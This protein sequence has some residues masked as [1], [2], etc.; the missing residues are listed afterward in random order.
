ME[1][2]AKIALNSLSPEEA[3]NAEI[4][5]F[6]GSFTAIDRCYMTS[7]LEAASQ[8]IRKGLFGGIRI[9][10]RPDAIDREVLSLLGQYGVT[11]IELGAQSMCDEVLSANRRGHTSQDVI[12]ASG[13]ILENG[14]SLGLQMMTGLYMSND[15]RDRKTALSLAALKPDT[16]RI[17]PTLVLKGSELYERYIRGEYRPQ[18]LDEAVRLCT[19]LL[20]IFEGRGIRVIRL[21]LHD[22]ES[23]RESTAAGPYHPSLRELCLSEQLF[24]DTLRA[25]SEAGLSSGDVRITVNPRCVSRF[26]GQNRRNIK[27]LESMGLTVYLRQDEALCLTDVRCEKTDK[28]AEL[29]AVKDRKYRKRQSGQ[30]EEA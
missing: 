17:Y 14:F 5:F 20:R 29:S 24:A 25:L 27:R 2:A 3:S 19:E 28:E 8:Y 12:N 6:G 1:Q 9:S 23:L 26:V 13:L 22:S 30:E 4:A 18:T 21:G 10:T 15:E 11:A 16:V 7:L